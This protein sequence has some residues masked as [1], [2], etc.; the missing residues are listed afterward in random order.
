MVDANLLKARLLRLDEYISILKKMQRYG[1]EEFLADPEHY[2]SAERFLQLAIECVNDIGNHVVADEALGA[3]EWKTDIPMRLLEHDFID[4]V[5]HDE[6]VKMIG[7]RNALVHDYVDVD[8][9]IVF[10]VLHTKLPVFADIKRAVC[11]WL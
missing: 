5:L 7:F 1:L 3:V 9:E 6:W 11:N 4:Q 10:R 8:R 2:G